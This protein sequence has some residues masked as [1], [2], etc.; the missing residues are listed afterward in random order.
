MSESNPFQSSFKPEGQPDGSPD[1]DAVIYEVNHLL[2][3]TKPWVRFLSVLGFI[4]TGLAVIVFLVGSV[5]GGV[6]P[7]PMELIIMVPMGVLFYLV[8]SILLWRYANRINDFLGAA[9]PASF[10]TALTAQKS[11]WKYLG[12]LALIIVAIYGVMFVV[13]GLI[14]A[15]G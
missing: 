14:A 6:A 7:G 2:A 13:G 11:F 3:Q 9:N 4:G 10:S 1:V 15:I 8:P 5:G 12:I